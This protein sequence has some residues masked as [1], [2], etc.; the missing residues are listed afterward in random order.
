MRFF[1]IDWPIIPLVAQLLTTIVLDHII[2]A[3]FPAVFAAQGLKTPKQ[4]SGSTS[5][6]V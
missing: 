2:L 5:N 1:A 4:K 6:T 3:T